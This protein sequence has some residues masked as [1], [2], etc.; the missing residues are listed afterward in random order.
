M[1]RKEFFEEVVEEINTII[2]KATDEELYKL[3]E[4]WLDAG[5]GERCIYGQMT[6]DCDSDRAKEL[7][8]K[9]FSSL[10]S[11]E[12]ADHS[13]PRKQDFIT[14]KDDFL[15][16]ALE[17][18]IFPNHEMA[19]EILNRIKYRKKLTVNKLYRIYKKYYD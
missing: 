5:D 11:F 8:S 18:F 2:D 6:G 4:D 15:Y 1:N 16:T 19:V 3:D 12:R 13:A 17:L 14:T 7:M 10:W 9:G